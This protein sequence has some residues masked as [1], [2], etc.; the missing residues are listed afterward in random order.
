MFSAVLLIARARRAERGSAAEI[1]H[2][3]ELRFPVELNMT[4]EPRATVSSDLAFIRSLTCHIFEDDCGWRGFRA[5]KML[6]PRP[7][8]P[9]PKNPQ[10]ARFP[11]QDQPRTPTQWKKTSHGPARPFCWIFVRIC[12]N[13]PCF[14]QLGFSAIVQVVQFAPAN[15]PMKRYASVVTQP[16]QF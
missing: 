11:C 4:R 12:T 8:L 9:A 14:F 3:A 16:S 2:T 5:G 7:L 13:E 6:L 10:H 15:L 1:H